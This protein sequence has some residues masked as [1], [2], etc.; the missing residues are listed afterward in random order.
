M[1][2]EMN[3]SNYYY[4]IKISLLSKESDL[5]SFSGSID[6]LFSIPN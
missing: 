2:F 1:E 6:F 5:E 4:E 3:D